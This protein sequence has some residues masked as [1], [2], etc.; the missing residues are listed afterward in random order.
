VT[1]GG[2]TAYGSL[3]A[4]DGSLLAVMTSQGLVR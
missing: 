1:S 2:V 4:R 3:R